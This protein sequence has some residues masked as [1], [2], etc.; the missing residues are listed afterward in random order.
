MRYFNLRHHLVLI[1]RSFSKQ[2]SKKKIPV[3]PVGNAAFSIRPLIMSFLPTNS[4]EEPNSFSI[5][6]PK[7]TIRGLTTASSNRATN[8]LAQPA[9]SRAVSD[10]AAC[11]GTTTAARPDSLPDFHDDLRLNSCG[12]SLVEALSSLA[13]CRLTDRQPRSPR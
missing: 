5:I 12:T 10:W 2:H 7:E 4:T 1:Y 6:I 8:C 3:G 13:L 11:C 9:R